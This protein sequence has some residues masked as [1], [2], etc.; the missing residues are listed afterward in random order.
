MNEKIYYAISWI[1][2]LPDFGTENGCFERIFENEEDA[3]KAMAEDASNEY[4]MLAD[5]CDGDCGITYDKKPD[6]ITLIDEGAEE[7]NLYQ[8]KILKVFVDG[9]QGQPF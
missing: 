9:T 2:Q 5:G 3:R 6:C 7:P 1:R 4:N 8:V